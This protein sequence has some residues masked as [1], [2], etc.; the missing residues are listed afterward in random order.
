MI[1][2]ATINV[3]DYGALGNG[4]ADNTSA[5]A[6]AVAALVAQGGGCLYIPKG[7]YKYTTFLITASNIC[8]RGDGMGV[9]V[10]RPQGWI[11]GIRFAFG[12]P[13]PLAILTNVG[14]EYITVDGSDQ[15]AGANDT[16]GNGIN[17]N[18]CAKAWV[19]FCEV[20]K[21]KQQ[22]IV[23]SYFPLDNPPTTF[24]EAYWVTDNLI[25]NSL[26]PQIAIGLEGL[27]K[28]TVV[29]RNVVRNV[30]SGSG[31][32]IFCAASG[33]TPGVVTNTSIISDNILYGLDGVGVKIE[34]VVQEV[35]VTGNKLTGF[36]YSMSIG[37]IDSPTYTFNYLISSNLMIDWATAG[38][39]AN[40]ISQN[41]KTIFSGNS[42][43]S[44]TAT[45]WAA[46]INRDFFVSGNRFQ[47]S[48]G[49]G[50]L[51]VGA[52]TVISGNY[53]TGPAN[54]SVDA[55]LSTGSVI[56]GNYVDKNILLA[57]DTVSF[58]NAGQPTPNWNYG[59]IGTKKNVT[60]P[61]VNAAPVSGTWAVGDKVWNF[62]PTAGGYIGWVCVTAGTPGTWKEFGTIAV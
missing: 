19:R 33:I 40:G 28:N 16:Y 26:S 53:I 30:N 24:Q 8:V 35:V 59:Y 51:L 38:F 6:A 31:V 45:P 49:T 7:V 54:Y 22:A 36:N 39:V 4:V 12:Y 62:T 34:G 32:G 29:S 41:S 14:V 1:N 58:D 50:I 52:G 56:S 11:D 21:T 23:S 44:T 47:V 18:S 25:D 57:S 48:T 42:L 5:F 46:I 20:K 13:V 9:T 17:I 55:S 60:N 27:Q 43:I 15:L 3:L 37:W 2:G 61:N 10:L